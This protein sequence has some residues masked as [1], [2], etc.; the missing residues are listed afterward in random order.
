MKRLANLFSALIILMFVVTSFVACESETDSDGIP[1]TTVTPKAGTTY[2]YAKQERD[3]VS[4]GSP[5]TTDSIVIATVLSSG[6]TFEGK[7]NVIS[8][9]DNSDTMRYVME[10]NGDVS[11]YRKNLFTY[12]DFTYVSPEPWGLKY[13]LGSKMS[14]VILFEHDTEMV[15]SSFPVPVHLVATVNYLGTEELKKGGNAFADG[16]K[17]EIVVVM[18]GSLSGVT[19]KVTGKQ[20]ISFDPKI[21]GYFRLSDY[22]EIPDVKVFGQTVVQGNT[23]LIEK[24]LIDFSLIK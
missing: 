3:S 20:T 6:T 11:I 12:G 14:G 7:S 16:G 4:G 17:A 5:T 13:S 24:I 18:T 15:V 8:L 23:S 19:V 9:V 10:A 21:G 1:S 22:I 2:T